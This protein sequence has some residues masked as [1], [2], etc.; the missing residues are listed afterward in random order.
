MPKTIRARAML[1]AS[2]VAFVLSA[3]AGSQPMQVTPEQTVLAFARLL[4]EGKLDDAYALLD[5]SYREH[6]SLEQWKSSLTQ[7]AQELIETSNALA[8]VQGPA[9]ES[10][11]LRYGGGEEVQL[12]RRDG[13]WFIASDIANYYDQ[14]TPRAALRTFVRAWQHK[15]YDVL[16]RLLPEADKEGITTDRLQASFRGEARDE[17]E[18][19][20]AALRAHLHAPIEIVGTHATMPY[21]ERAQ[22]LFVREHGS[23]K[24]EAPE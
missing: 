10:A 1:R 16:V 14:S 13:Q 17:M 7:N 9:Q 6:V 2:S 12:T 8:R 5:A 15:R 21:G 24:I 3:C 18:R 11:T 19:V 20:Q 22:L 23:W 4:N